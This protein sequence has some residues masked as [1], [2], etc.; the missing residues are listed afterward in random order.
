MSGL[1]SM[2][3]YSERLV[4][5]AV[6]ESDWWEIS[7]LRTDASV[8]RYLNR[9]TAETQEKALEFIR[10]IH[11]MVKT[12]EAFY[13][14]LCERANP[15]MIGTIC[16]W[17]FT[18]DRKQAEIGYE[19]HPASQGLGYMD[20]A[21]KVLIPFAVEQLSLQKLVAYT[22]SENTA[23]LRLLERNEFLPAGNEPDT[24]LV[25]YERTGRIIS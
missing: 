22:H 11:E 7:F 10:R 23:S 3:I 13:W 1:D 21:L 17:N 24:G 25:I 18:P 6:E 19:L 2:V 8:N 16:L 14:V 9:P 20:E 12:G 5:R 4:L 15:T